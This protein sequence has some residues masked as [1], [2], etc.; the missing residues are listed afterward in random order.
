MNVNLAQMHYNFAH[1][2]EIKF[3][4]NLNDNEKVIF[5]KITLN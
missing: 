5:L 1:L 4:F 2:S 3:A